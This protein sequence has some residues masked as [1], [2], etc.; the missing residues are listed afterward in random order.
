[1]E[2]LVRLLGELIELGEDAIV[3]GGVYDER[4]KVANRDG[5]RFGIRSSDSLEALPSNYISRKQK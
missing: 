4:D 5:S 1:M 2:W 3:E